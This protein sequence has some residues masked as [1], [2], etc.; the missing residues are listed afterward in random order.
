METRYEP[1]VTGVDRYGRAEGSVL[2]V[3][4]RSLNT[5][6]GTFYREGSKAYVQPHNRRIAHDILIDATVEDAQPG[7][8]VIAT[9]QEFPTHHQAPHAVF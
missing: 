5:V 7:D 9:I 6:V 3:L 8:Y 1:R 2:E 4:E